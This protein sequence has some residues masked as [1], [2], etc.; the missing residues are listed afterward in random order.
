MGR[1]ETLDK[2]HGMLAV[3]QK[4]SFMAAA[5]YQRRNQLLGMPVMVLSAIV[6]SAVF[7]SI[8]QTNTPTWLKVAVGLVSL[9]A[10]VMSGLQTFLSYGELAEKHKAAGVK[11]GTLR[12]EIEELTSSEAD[13]KLANVDLKSIRTRWDAID[14]EAPPLPPA[15][16]KQVTEEAKVSG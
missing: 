7:S 11:F 16:Y 9:S 10:T 15:I 14:Q 5:R 8:S 1:Q 6:G 3:L 13:P 4:G 2:W 12:R